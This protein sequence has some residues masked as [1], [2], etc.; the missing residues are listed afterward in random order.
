MSIVM[1]VDDYQKGVITTQVK[2]TLGKEKDKARKIFE[3]ETGVIFEHQDSDDMQMAHFGI[4]KGGCDPNSDE[5]C[6][7]CETN[8]VFFVRKRG[9]LPK[10]GVC[11]HCGGTGK[12]STAQYKHF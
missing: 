6:F 5:G 11:S 10:G 8:G 2:Y 3:K 1:V 7:N 9:S 4:R 12:A